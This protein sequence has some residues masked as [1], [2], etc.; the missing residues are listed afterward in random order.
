M[1]TICFQFAAIPH[2]KKKRKKNP[3]ENVKYEYGM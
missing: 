1:F 3:N 2:E